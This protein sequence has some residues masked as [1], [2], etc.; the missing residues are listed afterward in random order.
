MVQFKI[1]RYIQAEG[2]E[3]QIWGLTFVRPRFYRNPLSVV[4]REDSIVSDFEDPPCINHTIMGG[5]ETMYSNQ[6]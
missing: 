3:L 5:K 2:E 4:K 6:A 1:I